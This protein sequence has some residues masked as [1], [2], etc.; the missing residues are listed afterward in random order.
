MKY[1]VKLTNIPDI[2]T[3]E[4]EQG[5]PVADVRGRELAE[6]F[7]I[8]DEI[9]EALQDLMEEQNGPPLVRREKYW[10]AAYDGCDKILTRF[11]K[12]V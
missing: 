8:V 12:K 11:N 5:H 7:A 6:K 3:L 10:N 9:L 1:K 2:F 4:D